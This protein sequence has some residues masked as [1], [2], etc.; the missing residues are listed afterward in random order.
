MNKEEG[1][2]V[3]R[4]LVRRAAVTAPLLLVTLF[5]IPQAFALGIGGFDRPQPGLYP[6]LLSVLI[7]AVLIPI[8]LIDYAEDIEPFDKACM[9]VFAGAAAVALFIVLWPITGLVIAASISL[10]LWMW[11]LG[12]ERVVQSAITAVVT[13][14]VCAYTFG[15][16]LGVPLPT[17]LIG[18]P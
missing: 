12:K 9:R 16:L 1:P 17:G 3:G 7:I 8:F 15:V 11:R 14:V 5:A 2:V 4:D 18:L 6:L 13:S 10:F